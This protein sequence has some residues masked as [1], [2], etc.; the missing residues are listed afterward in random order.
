[1]RQTIAHT[2]R[3]DL[4]ERLRRPA[5]LV[6]VALTALAGFAFAPPAEAPYTIIDIGGFRGVSNAAWLGAMLTM[7][8]T[9]FVGLLG[10]FYVRG[11]VAYDVDSGVGQI[12]GASPLRRPAYLLGKW[13]S[14]WAILGL[15]TAI[16]GLMGVVLLLARGAPGDLDL[17]AL[18][19]PLLV[20]ALPTMG[21]VAG[22]ATLFDAVHPLRG[23]AGSVV[24]FV[25]FLATLGA[26]TLTVADP[27]G[28]STFGPSIVV[29][30]AAVYGPACGNE[31][32]VGIV[33]TEGPARTFVW[34]GMAWTLAVV[35]GQW[36]WAVMGLGL[37]LAGALLFDGFVTRR[38]P[39]RRRAVSAQQDTLPAIMSGAPQPVTLSPVTPARHTFGRVFLAEL[40]LLLQGRP[41]WWYAGAVGLVMGC[42]LSPVE[43]S[44][45]WLLPVAWLWPLL[46]L[47]ELGTREHHFGTVA[48]LRSA[49]GAVLRQVPAAW[50]AAAAVL[51][52]LGGGATF[53][54]A[55]SG[56]GMALLGLGATALLIPALALALGSW[57]G[58]PR[59]FEL[60]YLILW[61]GALNGLPA[62]LAAPSDPW[63][64]GA[65]LLLTVA[66]LGVAALGRQR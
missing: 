24:Y 29:A 38:A 33:L 61:Y 23:A 62:L 4:Q 6:V 56:D 53:T 65:R 63:Q 46:L 30:C 15:V 44:S 28:S 58:S 14:S 64:I 35:V 12:L 31:L 59:L 51:L 48:L 21:L 45:R 22:F 26:G 32:A 2:L 9:Q 19:L 42:A 66:L 18:L 16:A 43:L 8:L 34:P 20:I 47:S 37:S 5:F 3:A 11:A 25:L 55:R 60:I 10:F 17:P 41:W 13:L 39:T 27:S 50:L 54:L 52:L 57:S 49:P 36:L 7:L 1:M 40:R